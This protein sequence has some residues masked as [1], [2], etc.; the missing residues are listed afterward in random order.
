ML[1]MES[2][3]RCGQSMATDIFRR[4]AEHPQPPPHLFRNPPPPPTPPHP[5]C[6]HKAVK[7]IIRP[8]HWSRLVGSHASSNVPIMR[9]AALTT[10]LKLSSPL[11]RNSTFAQ[12]HPPSLNCLQL[13]DLGSGFGFSHLRI[14]LRIF[15]YYLQSFSSES[16]L[17]ICPNIS[18]SYTT[19]V[20]SSSV[21]PT[22]DNQ[23]S[24]KFWCN[25]YAIKHSVSSSGLDLSFGIPFYY[26]L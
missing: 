21:L 7:S 6:T 4:I 18:S 2:E 5:L 20:A 26:I 14:Q 12:L 25:D 9:E 10:R 17:H 22:H 16:G 23:S 19:S 24:P 8:A 11:L 1:I 13:I 15:G 3:E